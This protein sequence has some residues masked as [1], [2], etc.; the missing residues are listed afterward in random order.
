MVSF[1]AVIFYLVLLDAVGANI[2]S[3]CCGKWYKKNYKGIYK[4]FPSTKGWAIA[5]LVLV[6]WVG[7]GLTRLAII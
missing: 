7:Y 2:L 4:H 5:Y 3:W 1:E 6:L